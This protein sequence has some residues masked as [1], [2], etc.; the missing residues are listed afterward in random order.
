MEILKSSNEMSSLREQLSKKS[1]KKA[2]EISVCVSTGC[3]ARGALDVLGVLNEQL[4]AKGLTETINIKE[5]GCQGFCEKGPK[6]TLYPEDVSYF[7]VTPADVPEVI[8]SIQKKKVIE[9]LLYKDPIDGVKEKLGDIPF[10][11]HQKRILLEKNEK[12]D[13]H[14]IEDYIKV[15]GYKA[16]QKALFEMSDTAVLE[17]I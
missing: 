10:Y 14:H 12:I 4:A 6:I 11:K 2:S 16:L 9:R 8:E 7:H 3:V 1:P 17:E 5:T 15:G 13:P